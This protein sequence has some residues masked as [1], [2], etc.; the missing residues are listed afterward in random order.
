MHADPPTC[1]P[2][3]GL[4]AVRARLG[5]WDT[6][7]VLDADGVLLGRLGRSALASDEDVSA[8]EAMTDGPSTIRPSARLDWS[9][10]RMDRNNLSSLPVTTSEG[11][12]LGLLTR[13]DAE[14]ALLGA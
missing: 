5:D 8:E 2:D 3:D 1:G 13:E 7:F 4:Q 9:I 10:A 6:C 12:F 14:A 11:R